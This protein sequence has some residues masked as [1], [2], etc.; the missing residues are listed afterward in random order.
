MAI[1]L[2][3]HDVEFAAAHADR[4]MILERGRVIAAGPTAETLFGQPALRTALQRLTGRPRPARPDELPREQGSGE[5][6]AEH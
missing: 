6:H 5:K 1:I 2:A 3:T 4:A